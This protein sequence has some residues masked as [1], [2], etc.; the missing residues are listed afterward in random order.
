MDFRLDI[1]NVI[2][3]DA[4][5]RDNPFLFKFLPNEEDPSAF[6]QEAK[7]TVNQPESFEFAKELRSVSEEFGEKILLGEVSGNKSIIRRFL[8][9]ETNNG[10]GLVFDFEMLLFKFTADYFRKLIQSIEAH[11]PDPFMPVYVFSNHDKRRSIHKLGDN[12]RKAKLLHMLQLTVRGVPCMY[13]GEE[14]GMTDHNFP[15]NTALDPIP[16]KFKFIPRFV[17]DMLDLTINRDEVR[18][19]MQWDGTRNAGFSSAEKTWLPVHENYD[20]INVETQR[21]DADSLLNTIRALMK[22]R[23]DEKAIH[24]GSLGII[25]GLPD[26]VLGY[27]RMINDEK[28]FILLNFSE[29]KIKFQFENS[30]A[31][32]NLSKMDEVKDQ[33]IHLGK[34]GGIILKTKN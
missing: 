21:K 16:H 32:F 9:D 3:K 12:P 25:K 13:Y 1:F 18:T 27:T 26:C 4:E 31:I 5:F 28:V 14:L 8:G 34:F 10:L 11:F 29:K 33:T 22:I 2:Y 20:Q 17:F 7:H 19:P 23:R 30:K 6:F 24:E 15:F